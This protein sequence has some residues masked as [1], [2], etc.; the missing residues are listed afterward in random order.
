M[1]DGQPV[2]GEVSKAVDRLGD[3]VG[4]VVQVFTTWGRIEYSL[5]PVRYEV[6]MCN[7]KIGYGP[8]G[9]LT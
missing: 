2:V 4:E 3:A 1:G 6:R 5:E 7:L 9:Q 8:A